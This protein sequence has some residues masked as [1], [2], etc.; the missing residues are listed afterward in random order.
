MQVPSIVQTTLLLAL[1]FSSMAAACKQSQDCCWNDVKGCFNQH[2]PAQ[3]TLCQTAEYAAQ[4]CT[5]FG[6]KCDGADCCSISTGKG[7]GCPK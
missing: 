1:G 6:V 2:S 5:N 3:K 4:F 7:R